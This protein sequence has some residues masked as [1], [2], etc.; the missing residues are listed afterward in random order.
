MNDSEDRAGP[1]RVVEAIRERAQEEIKERLEDDDRPTYRVG[2]R[3]YRGRIMV[4][5]GGRGLERCELRSTMPVS[6]KRCPTPGFR[7]P[8]AATLTSP[9]LS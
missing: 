1:L 4:V 5:E 2:P 3:C 6:Q 9:E 8:T 7:L